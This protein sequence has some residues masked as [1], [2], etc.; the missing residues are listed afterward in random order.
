MT[1]LDITIELL[2]WFQ[3]NDVINVERDF[4]NIILIS[5][6]EGE[7]KAL[8]LAGL[9]HLERRELVTSI[10]WESSDLYFLN[11]NLDSLEQDIKIEQETATKISQV[12]N[13]FCDA[14]EDHKDVVDPTC[15]RQKDILHLALILEAWQ[16]EKKDN[17]LDE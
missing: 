2:K 6:N 1:V 5:E 11:K 3:T 12:I 7:D 13:H 16:K 17:D 8:V 4:K 10:E 14:I 15:I 9:K